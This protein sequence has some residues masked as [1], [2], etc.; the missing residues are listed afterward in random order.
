MKHAA[1][2]SGFSLIEVMCA[3]L[4]LG[5]G[6]VGF[7]QAITT[8]LGSSK[9]SEMQTTAALFAAG[10]IESLR[11]DDYLVDGS[12]DGDC[13]NELPLY[14]WRQS[15]ESTDIKGLH[16]V[17]VTIEN[18][19]TSKSIYEL[20]TLLFDPPLT[21]E[22]DESAAKNDRDKSKKKNRRQQ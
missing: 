18:S 21:S 11:A 5:V 15:I 3:I 2:N 1:N 10:R 7:T 9:D 22:A 17:T 14:Q 8:A 13:G 19:R 6:L 4:I 12:S 20:E 16:H